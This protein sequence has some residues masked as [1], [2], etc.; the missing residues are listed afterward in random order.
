MDLD[1]ENGDNLWLKAE[2][3]ELSS[4]DEKVT[5]FNCDHKSKAPPPR[6]YKKI[7]V[8]IDMLL[9]MM[10]DARQDW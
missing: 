7:R 4:V 6:D 9:N 1:K 5:F 10:V 2:G 3:T 8:R